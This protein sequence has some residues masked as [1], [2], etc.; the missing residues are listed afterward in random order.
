MIYALRE[1]DPSLITTKMRSKGDQKSDV[2]MVD[3]NSLFSKSSQLSKEIVTKVLLNMHKNYDS[4]Q[5]KRLYN[6]FSEGYNSSMSG[7]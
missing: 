3:R 5:S 6:M 4:G 1:P 7:P 2:S